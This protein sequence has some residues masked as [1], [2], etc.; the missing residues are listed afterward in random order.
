MKTI[1]NFDLTKS[2]GKKDK[3]K[4]EDVRV[5]S[6]FVIQ[7]NYNKSRSLYYKFDHDKAIAMSYSNGQNYETSLINDS[8]D[9]EDN[10]AEI[11]E[12]YFIEKYTY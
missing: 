8:S 2:E 4:F 9:F 5:G 7:F 11:V 10:Y 1:E 12:Q 6:Y 3:T